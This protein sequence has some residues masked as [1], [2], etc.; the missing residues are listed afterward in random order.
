MKNKIYGRKVG[1]N[2]DMV[3]LVEGNGVS[4]SGKKVAPQ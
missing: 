3:L 2:D 4:L 1:S